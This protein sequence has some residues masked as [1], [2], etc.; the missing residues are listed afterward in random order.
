MTFK[1]TLRVSDSSTLPLDGSAQAHN[2]GVL[3]VRL[4][5]TK[6]PL[7]LLRSIEYN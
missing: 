1:A 2:P 4:S 7:Y 6:L 5:L 3:M